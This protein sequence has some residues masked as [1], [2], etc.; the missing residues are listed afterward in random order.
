MKLPINYSK[1]TWVER[2]R[3]R[4]LYINQQDGKCYYCGASLAEAPPS[5]ILAKKITPSLYPESFFKYPIHL[6][7]SHNTGLTIGA[8]HNYCNAVLWEYEK[9]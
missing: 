7:H 6:H 9:E 5:H 4:K 3:A 2:K 8:V 1:A